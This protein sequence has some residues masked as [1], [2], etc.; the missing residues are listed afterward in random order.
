MFDYL[1]IRKIPFWLSSGSRL[2]I[3]E[4]PE[5]V[6]KTLICLSHLES[7]YPPWCCLDF[8]LSALSSLKSVGGPSPKRTPASWLRGSFPK[9]A[10][11]GKSIL[12]TIDLICPHYA[13]DISFAGKSIHIGD[14]TLLLTVIVHII[15]KSNL[16][17]LLP[18]QSSDKTRFH[19]PNA[20]LNP[21]C[22]Y[23]RTLTLLLR[24][25]SRALTWAAMVLVIDCSVSK[26][27]TKNGH[28]YSHSLRYQSP[29][30]GVINK[31]GKQCDKSFAAGGISLS[32]M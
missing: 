9:S 23:L 6:K 18:Y 11:W 21:H 5:S 15:W 17:Y 28:W 32:F 10:I 24:S 22:Q 8:V 20:H 4:A 13:L 1:N 30:D 25:L 12:T 7:A 16:I 2:N 3:L 29:S 26:R 14:W 19:P 27:P 31:L